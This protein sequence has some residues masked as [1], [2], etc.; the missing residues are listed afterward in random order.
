M[1]SRPKMAL[2][3]LKDS[4]KAFIMNGYPQPKLQE[5]GRKG[6]AVTITPEGTAAN[7]SQPS[8]GRGDK[9]AERCRLGTQVGWYLQ[10]SNTQAFQ[11]HYPKHPCQPGSDLP[12]QVD[13]FYRNNL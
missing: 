13:G 4:Y 11:K 8:P 6:G 7:K 2:K 1:L 10:P 3:A 9:R 5:G 12:T